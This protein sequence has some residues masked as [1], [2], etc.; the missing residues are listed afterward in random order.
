MG[1]LELYRILGIDAN[2]SL[3]EIKTAYRVLAKRYHPDSSKIDSHLQFDRVTQAYKLLSVRVKENR[4]IDFPVRETR[5]SPNGYTHAGTTAGK[6]PG[7]RADI[8]RKAKN[9][10]NAESTRTGSHKT[11]DTD[12]RGHDPKGTGSGTHAQKT[13]TTNARQTTR[14]KTKSEKPERNQTPKGKTKTGTT[15]SGIYNAGRFHTAG[16]R[17]DDAYEA[18]ASRMDIFGLGNMLL[19]SRSADLRTFAARRLGNSGKKTAYAFLRKAL[20]DRDEL[21]VRSVV[22]AI[23]NLRIL[24]SAGELSAVFVRCKAPVRMEILKSV[25]KIGGSG[26]FEHS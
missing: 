25:R 21:V 1:E 15:R 20:D 10:R 16:S 23:G 7:T 19:T 8:R 24:Q 18:A 13:W 3:D 2:A 5:S 4:L 11:S 17:F 14:S 9:G 6:T 26:S 22:E 12:R